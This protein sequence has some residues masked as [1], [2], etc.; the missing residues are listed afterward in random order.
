[1]ICI[2]IEFW[3]I[4]VKSHIIKSEALQS[5]IGLQS[6][7]NNGIC[8]NFK[9]K[10]ITDECYLVFLEINYNISLNFKVD[11]EKKFNERE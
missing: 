3:K 10:S 9:I 5:I 4:A 2:E 6:V 1:M 8:K 11:K 7:H